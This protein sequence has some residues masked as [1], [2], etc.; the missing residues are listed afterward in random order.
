MV[1]NSFM[2]IVRCMRKSIVYKDCYHIGCDLFSYLKY[3]NEIKYLLYFSYEETR[4]DSGFPT[5][6]L[7]F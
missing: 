3:I 6:G 5:M 7:V 1:Q 4:E 2:E